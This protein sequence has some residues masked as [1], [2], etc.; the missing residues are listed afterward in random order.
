MRQGKVYLDFLQNRTGQTLAAPYS[1]RPWPGATV[2]A[3]LAWR[4]VRRGLD[5][6]RFTIRTMPKRLER[7]GDLW[8]PVLG[9]GID[10]QA[11]LARLERLVR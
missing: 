7:L 11:C 6:A 9:R 4:E 8:R 10:L 5:P 2:S 1:V 3:P